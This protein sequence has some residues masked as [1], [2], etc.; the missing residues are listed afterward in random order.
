MLVTLNEWM[1]CLDENVPVD[2]AYLDFKKAFDS[3]PHKRLMSKL[4]GYG[5]NGKLFSWIEDFLSDREQ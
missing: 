5:V 3:V 2:A 4:R 1:S